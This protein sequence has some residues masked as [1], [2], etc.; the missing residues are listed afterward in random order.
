VIVIYQ[1][2]VVGELAPDVGEEAL[3]NAMHGTIK[4]TLGGGS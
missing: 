4:T 2:E 3:L 1:G